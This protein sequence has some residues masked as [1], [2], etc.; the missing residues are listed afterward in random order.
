M[1]SVMTGWQSDK[2][3]TSLLPNTGSHGGACFR[4]KLSF[5]VHSHSLTWAPEETLWTLSFHPLVY[6]KSHQGV[7]T[8]LPGQNTWDNLKTKP[9]LVLACIQRPA[10]LAA[11]PFCCGPVTAQYSAEGT[12]TEEVLLLMEARKHHMCVGGI[13]SSRAHHQLPNFFQGGP[14]F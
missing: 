7:F 10:S 1:P 3:Q 6:E 2:R 11:C 5:T 13:P 9:K 14:P 8:L 12:Q 4:L